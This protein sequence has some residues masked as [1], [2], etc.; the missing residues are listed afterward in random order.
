MKFSE[1]G[2]VAG[3]HPSYPAGQKITVK[4]NK[5]ECRQRNVAINDRSCALT[6][7]SHHVNFAARAAHER[8][9]TLI[10][11]G[12]LSDGAAGSMFETLTALTCTIDPNAINQ[13][14]GGGASCTF[15]PGPCILPKTPQPP[16]SA[17]ASCV[18]APGGGCGGPTVFM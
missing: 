18:T 12:V 10:E 17:F 4:T 7:G 14:A 16:H 13:N 6:F 15:T 3:Q 9:A 5:I 8:Y 1:K 2:V 11:A